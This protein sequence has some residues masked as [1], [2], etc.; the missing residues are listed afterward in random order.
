[1]VEYISESSSVFGVRVG[2][3]SAFGGTHQ[4]GGDL[5]GDGGVVCLGHQEDDQS[6][7]C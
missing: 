5:C 1:M 4:C 7:G 6:G 3:G 2:E